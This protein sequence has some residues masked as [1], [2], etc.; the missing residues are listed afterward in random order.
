MSGRGL[1]AVQAVHCDAQAVLLGR[2]RIRSLTQQGNQELVLPPT[3]SSACIGDCGLLREPVKTECGSGS[4][5]GGSGRRIGGLL[6][7]I[8]GNGLVDGHSWQS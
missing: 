3:C 6:M 7:G 1:Q 8:V 5:S 4:R 2:I